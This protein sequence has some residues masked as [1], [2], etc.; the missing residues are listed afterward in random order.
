M[1][2][3]TATIK[4]T[5][6]IGR[7]QIPY[8]IY[9]EGAETLV[10]INGIQQSMAI[11]S[12][13]VQRFAHKY[14]I[15]LFDFP[16]QGKGKVLSGPQDVSLDEQVAILDQLLL[17][18]GVKGKPTLCSA[19]WGGVI[20]A[21]F[22]VRY[23]KRINKLILSGIG[24]KPNPKMVEV[25]S[26]GSKLPMENRLEIA[27]T[28][29]D[30]FG[31]DLPEKV[32]N[33]IIGQFER[34]DREALSA[35]YHHGMFILSCDSLDKVIDLKSI[36]CKTILLRGENDVIID[37]EDLVVLAAEIPNAEIRT[38]KGAGHFLHLE[39]DKLMDIYA[40]ILAA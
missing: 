33:S 22:T 24:T 35:F 18:T 28:L 15:L 36:D 34:M 14:Q 20:A 1:M 26:K 19:S 2:I 39:N 27:K 16:H 21:S 32:K 9:G 12:D 11:W 13:F 3:T 38:I 31:R 5:V 40:E 7:F 29:I 6:D 4:K 17:V 25:I 37:A 30:G 10:C 8:R 23:P